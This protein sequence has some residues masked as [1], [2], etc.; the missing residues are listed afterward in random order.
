MLFLHHLVNIV[1][2][3]KR[4]VYN[5]YLQTPSEHITHWFPDV[6]LLEA[7]SIFDASTIS[8]DLEFHGNQGQKILNKHY[9]PHNVVY[10]G[11]AKFELKVFNSVLEPMES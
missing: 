7:F 8:G 6:E 5:K 1:K 9:G 3:F 2:R 10:P 11:A 4:F